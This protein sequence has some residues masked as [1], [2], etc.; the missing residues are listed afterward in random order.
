MTENNKNPLGYEKITTLLMKF[1][2]PS[3]ISML[4][5]AIYNIVDQIFIGNMIGYHG[6]AATNVAYPLT[7]ISLAIALLIGTGGA[8]KQNLLLGAKKQEQANKAVCN[9]I[10]LLIASGVVLGVITLIFLKPLL[11][12]FGA[13]KD[14]MPYAVDYTGI[15]AIGLPFATAITGLN[16]LIRAD[17]SPA[18]SMAS[19][20]SGAVI[21]T[22]LDP[23]FIHFWGI[24]GAAVATVL[25]QFVSF[26]M[27]ILYIRKFRHVE[28]KKEYF[29]IDRKITGSICALG[30]ASF[31]NQLAMTVV[32]IVMN[33]SMTTY[34]AQSSYGSDI[35][36]ACSGIVMK[37]SMLIMAVVIGIAQGHQPIVS[38][39][40]GAG[41]YKRV[42]EAY[43]R[44]VIISSCVSVLGFI[45]LQLFPEQI[46]SFFGKEKNPEY[47][48]FGVRLLKIF[49][50][51][52]ALNGIQPVT[53]TFFT[54]IGKAIKGTFIALTR[55][56]IFLVPLILILP[57]FLGIDGI[58]YAGPIADTAAFLLAVILM[59]IEFK[60]IKKL[61]A[62]A[63]KE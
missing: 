51:G 57:V 40:Y 16:H 13:T 28:I 5:S 27:N 43:L 17:G 45:A 23:I 42:R 15:I 1:A 52:M 29:R 37:V 50:M 60:K 35:P 39:N 25:G 10:T 14:V 53:T 26:L 59:V 6:N 54:A 22:I 36:L 63:L 30:I 9:S 21:N 20:L 41:N 11:E 33:N 49:L 18:Y 56:V 31:F 48:R 46:L 32:Q 38:F 3:V 19:M 34:G 12:F 62:E 55:Q 61:E 24:K 44:A 58:M 8:A 47:V 7:T 2:I 4:V